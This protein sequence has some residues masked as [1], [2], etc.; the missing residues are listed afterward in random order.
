MKTRQVVHMASKQ[1]VLKNYFKRKGGEESGSSESSDG[2]SVYL[3]SKS[4][5]LYDQPMSWTRVKDVEQAVSQRVT[6]FDV[7]N[8]MEQDKY[9]KQ[10]RKDAARQPGTLLFDPESFRDM[11]AELTLARYALDQAQLLE[12]AKVASKIRKTLSADVAARGNED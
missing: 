10:I 3:P 7:Q 11:Y 9:L 2:E 5:R 1:A 6:I 12:Y 8:D 4:K